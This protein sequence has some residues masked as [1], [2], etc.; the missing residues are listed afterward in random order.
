MDEPEPAMVEE[1]PPKWTCTACSFENYGAL[2][3]CE[4]CETARPVEGWYDA[5]LE[6]VLTNGQVVEQVQQITACDAETAVNARAHRRPVFQG[7]RQPT[8][9][10][11]D[12]P[13]A[14]GGRDAA[15]VQAGKARERAAAASSRQL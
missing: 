2:N 11:L 6:G 5:S 14:A 3:E 4:M 12:C 9:R 15:H 13:L 8:R 10:S 7:A 1:E